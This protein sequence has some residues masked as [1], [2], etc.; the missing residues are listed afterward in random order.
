MYV[1][2]TKSQIRTLSLK[3]VNLIP[4]VMKTSVFET[5][6]KPYLTATI[7]IRDNQNIIDGLNIV[8][9]EDVTIA[10]SSPPNEA[11]WQNQFKVLSLQG[12][13]ENDNLKSIIYKIDVIGETYLQDRSQLVQSGHTNQPG[14]SAI[15]QVWSKYL[16][17]DTLKIRD[18]SP[19]M[20]QE[21]FNIINKKPFTAIYDLMRTLTG[22]PYAAG[23]ALLFRDKDNVNL[24]PLETLLN[25]QSSQETFVQK[26]TWGAN[27]F[28]KDIYR[29]IIYAEAKSN[30]GASGGRSSIGEVAAAGIQGKQVFDFATANLIFQTGKAIESKVQGRSLGTILN[31]V[32]SQAQGALGGLPNIQAFNSKQTPNSQAPHNKTMAERLLSA[33]ARNG[34]QL[35]LKVP[36]QTGINVTVGKGITANLLP[37]AGD[38]GTNPFSYSTS[39]W[40]LVTDLCHELLGENQQMV[41]TTTMQC[42]KGGFNT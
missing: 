32:L 5:V 13:A 38:T 7:E 8:G 17:A 35:E 16:S 10:F 9:G 15:Q 34:P 14:T 19:S 25:D 31:S 30:R 33:N 3:G 28:D 12:Q 37:P 4:Y 36:L 6:C 2:P 23:N 26:E 42:I 27:F 22:G 21:A 24:A 40:Y 39:G 20:F 29:A 41:G 1:Q 11:V 18:Q